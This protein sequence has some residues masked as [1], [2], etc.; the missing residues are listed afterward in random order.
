M[1]FRCVRVQHNIIQCGVNTTT[2]N[3]ISI[4]TT[5]TATI[6][7]RLRSLRDGNFTFCVCVCVRVRARARARTSFGC[8]SVAALDTAVLLDGTFENNC[9]Q[10]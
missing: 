2:A 3:S 6:I 1:Q 4:T 9:V 5:P 8:Y 7:G 10:D